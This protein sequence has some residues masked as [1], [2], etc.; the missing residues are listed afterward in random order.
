MPHG[1]Q[2]TAQI[3]GGIHQRAIQIEQDCGDAMWQEGTH[4]ER[5]LKNQARRQANR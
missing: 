1:I 3:R 2:R 4:V 5:V